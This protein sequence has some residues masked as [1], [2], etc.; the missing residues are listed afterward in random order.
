MLTC[1]LPS[2]D[3]AALT[4]EE[5]HLIPAIGGTH[6]CMHQQRLYESIHRFLDNSQWLNVQGNTDISG[7]T[8][9]EL[10]AQFDSM[11]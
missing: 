1:K 10:F 2:A 4:A 11:G 9:L 3:V 7:S 8:W 5:L 6:S